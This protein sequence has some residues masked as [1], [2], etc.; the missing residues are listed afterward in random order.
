MSAQPDMPA[1]V[2]LAAERRFYVGAALGVV[3]VV[4][5]GFSVDL[6]LLHDLGSL[7]VLVRVHGG[8][9][10][11]WVALFVTQTLLVARRRIAWHRRVGVLGAALAAA[12]V[13]T[14]SATVLAAMRLGG[15]H[16]PP[17]IP[18]PLFAAFSF[19]D[20]LSFAILVSSA[21]ALRRR[22]AWH[23]R[24][25][26]LATILVLDAALA[27]FINVYTSW[28]L[29]PSI[30]RDALILVCVAIDTWRYRRVHPAFIAGG[31]L[32]FVTDPV[33]QWVA[34]LPTWARLCAWLG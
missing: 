7:S 5:A 8:V 32:V 23:K 15:R 10:F 19:F 25:M 2:R 12:V 9:M 14:D 4:L 16:L 26:L 18:V 24:L 27:R 17:G 33:A 6:D 20:L 13:V 11:A 34:T 31:V 1:A 21:I 3:V 30:A 28:D 22:S 29:D